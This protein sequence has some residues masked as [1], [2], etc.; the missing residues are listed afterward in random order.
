MF[1]QESVSPQ[2]EGVGISGPM[3]CPEIGY[4]WV[5]MSRWGV[6]MSKEG[7]YRSGTVISKSFVGK[8]FLRSKWKYELTVHFKHEMI[9]K[10][11]PKTSNKVEFR[12][13]RVRINRARPVYLGGM[14]RGWVHMIL[15]YF[16]VYV[17][18]YDHLSNM[19]IFGHFVYQLQRINKIGLTTDMFTKTIPGNSLNNQSIV[20]ISFFQL[21]LL[22]H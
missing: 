2:G 19:A 6:C 22:N 9:G 5:G 10:Y 20:L 12:I 3:S 11:Y 14:S 16:L 7:G 21:A 15:E 8:D 13:N 1:S 17:N 18:L 4:L